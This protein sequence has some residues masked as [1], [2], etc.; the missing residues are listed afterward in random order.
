MKIKKF[1]LSMKIAL[2]VLIVSLMGISILAYISYYQSKKIFTE[3]TAQ[4]VSKNIDQ[5]TNFIQ[6]NIQKL[7]YNITIFSY[8]PS[9]KGFMRSYFDKYK[10]DEK[11]NKTFDQYKKDVT[12]IMKLMMKQ[13]PAYFQIRII[14]ARNGQEILKLIRNSLNQIETVKKALLQNKWQRNY[15]QETLN[16]KRNIYISKI[17]LNREFHTIEY[18]IKPTIRIAKIIFTNGKKSGIT[19]INANIKKLFH[20]KNLRGIKD[21]NTYIAN[22][23]GYYIFN[24]TNP[25]KEYAWEFGKDYKITDDFPILTNFYKSTKKTFSYI[26]YK[27]NKIY[28]ARKVYIYPN[29][30][31]VILKTTSPSIFENK[32]KEYMYKLGFA[33]AVI[34][35]LIAL[36]TTVLVN[37]LTRPIKKLTEIANKIAFSKGKIHYDIEIKSNDEIGE[38]ANSFKIMLNALEDSKKE[39]EKFAET[40]ENEVE[41]KTKELQKINRNLQKIVEEKVNELREKDQALLQQSKMAAMGEMIGAIAHQWR[42]PLN[43]LA[44]NIQMLEDMI[45]NG[46]I[47]DKNI[48]EFI[49]KNMQTIQFMSNTIDDFRNFFRKDKEAVRFNVKDAI[50]KTI[51]L[52]KAQL[53]NH[54]IEI[55]TD[56]KDA[57]TKGYKNEFMQTIL[58]II[59]NS[60]DA[61]VEKR[62]K[63]GDFKGQIDI[64]NKIKNGKIIITI[65]D[66]GGGI[67][68]DSQHRIFEPYF[69][70]KD[71]G[72]GT[73]MG[74]YMVKEIIERMNGKVYFKNTEKG[75]EFIIEL[76]KDD[77]GIL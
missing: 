28:E 36:I 15:V 25:E 27:H 49:N 2:L 19:V 77:D 56:L 26:D 3:H 38:L 34:A 35:L 53:K 67:P 24:K 76:L 62:E 22:M 66:N 9:V 33:I 75:A 47:D 18:P 68:Q 69:T 65:S 40:L 44:I 64:K 21:T 41:N 70:T 13:N 71:E 37:L 48:H 43:T 72:K 58:N 32:S 45:D 60:K 42:Q 5:Y 50:E 74:L 17:N 12:T 23:E 46:E 14:D 55:K 54:N 59:S 6:E 11:T 57:Y 52:Q 51:N 39:L 8:N 16:S 61:I 31:I 20:F 29:R 73:G 7:K 10:Y 30:Y 63:E 1:S 4:I